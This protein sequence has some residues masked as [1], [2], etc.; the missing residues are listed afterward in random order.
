MF[1]F[2][3]LSSLGASL[4]STGTGDY[5]SRESIVTSSRDSNIASTADSTAVLV[6]TSLADIRI[7]SR[8]DSI[9]SVADSGQSTTEDNERSASRH[10]TADTVNSGVSSRC[11]DS[12][13]SRNSVISSRSS[14]SRG[15]SDVRRESSSR[16]EL[17]PKS[18][19]SVDGDSGP[20]PE[21]EELK[22]EDSLSLQK[23]SSPDLLG[24]SDSDTMGTSS[25]YS[26]GGYQSGDPSVSGNNLYS[27]HP[28]NRIGSCER[29]IETHDDDN[30]VEA[31]FDHLR[32]DRSSPDRTC[33]QSEPYHTE[34]T[35][36]ER[37]SEHTLSKSSKRS[38]HK[39][40]HLDSVDQ[41]SYDTSAGSTTLDDVLGSLLALP[42][43]SRSPSP[44][45]MSNPPQY[46]R[47]FSHT[48]VSRSDQ[49]SL[50]SPLPSFQSLDSKKIDEISYGSYKN[51]DTGADTKSQNYHKSLSYTTSASSSDSCSV[52]QHQSHTPETHQHSH[53]HPHQQF[54]SEHSDSSLQDHPLRHS[55]EHQQQQQ[56]S[57]HH[58]HTSHHQQHYHPH[59]QPHSLPY[60]QPH[61]QQHQHHNPQRPEFPHGS[62]SDPKIVGARLAAQADDSD[63]SSV[64]FYLGRDEGERKE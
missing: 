62:V 12:L 16:E 31:E 21:S 20:R 34:H 48:G 36:S 37:R 3:E 58:S 26:F 57:S 6:D 54:Y 11:V 39:P 42:S 46:G 17:M 44:S 1:I 8:P 4:D 56:P 55:E 60:H 32:D 14:S 15:S 18:P 41:L 59:Q 10:S 61:Q 5:C 29:L 35:L 27:D 13:N 30:D 50:S 52:P 43:A 49:D 45:Q 63:R 38:E 7:D 25:Q 51:Q 2:A 9:H 28:L 23:S 22:F 24:H 64:T 19:I 53:S 33:S 40:R 47:Y